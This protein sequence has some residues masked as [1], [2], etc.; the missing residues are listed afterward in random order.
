M[1]LYI[2][3]SEAM[4]NNYHYILFINYELDHYYRRYT[5]LYFVYIF[6]FAILNNEAKEKIWKKTTH[7]ILKINFILLTFGN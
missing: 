5:L 3:Q 1:K 7:T 2:R 4:L 6:W